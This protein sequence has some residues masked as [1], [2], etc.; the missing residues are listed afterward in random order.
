MP[1]IIVLTRTIPQQFGNASVGNSHAVEWQRMQCATCCLAQ[2]CAANMGS[3]A[4]SLA[5]VR[6]KTVELGERHLPGLR[7]TWAWAFAV[8]REASHSSFSP[9]MLLT[10]SL[11]T[12][13]LP[14]HRFKDG[15]K[16]PQNRNRHHARSTT[17]VT[18]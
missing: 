16:H 7:C 17:C 3:L 11:Q 8:L 14:L 4:R 18:E 12:K 2:L 10:Q 15:P 5:L 1:L 6:L 13:I 9:A